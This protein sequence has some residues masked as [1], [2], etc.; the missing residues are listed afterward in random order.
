VHGRSLPPPAPLGV[1]RPR[2]DRRFADFVDQCL[3]LN[4]K[5]RPTAEDAARVLKDVR[6]EPDPTSVP[7]FRSQP[8]P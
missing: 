8:R 2:L 7:S 4:P 5:A 6:M 3:S 1:A